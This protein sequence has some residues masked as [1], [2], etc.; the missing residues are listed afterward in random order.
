MFSR[1][2]CV[3]AEAELPDEIGKT[4]SR[5]LNVCVRFAAMRD[6]NRAAAGARTATGSGW[7]R[8]GRPEARRGGRS[9]RDELVELRLDRRWAWPAPPASS[10][11]RQATSDPRRRRRGRDGKR[12]VTHVARAVGRSGA[13]E[14]GEPGEMIVAWRRIGSAI[15]IDRVIEA[16][17]SEWIAI[18]GNNS[19]PNADESGFGRSASRRR[20]KKKKKKKQA[21]LA[22]GA[23]WKWPT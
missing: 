18:K 2:N 13:A 7:V 11:R 20:R 17:V 10:P 12:V 23:R 3:V 16:V 22:L 6:G 5:V 8:R 4:L 19:C 14:S 9:G 21:P 15:S 1:A